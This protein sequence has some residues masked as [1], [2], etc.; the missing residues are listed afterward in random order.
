MITLR[1]HDLLLLLAVVT[2][3]GSPFAYAELAA[4]TGVSPGEVYKGLKRSEAAGLYHHETRQPEHQ[5]LCDFLLHGVRHAFPAVRGPLAR[6]VPTS[7]AAPP[8]A[9]LF[10]GGMLP[11]DLTPVWPSPH[12][13]R[14]GYGVEPLYPTVPE[15]APRSPALYELL[16][17]TDAIREGRARERNE[18]ERELRIRLAL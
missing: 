13:T 7:V 1:P 15:V 17:L 9:D 11:P 18:A 4:S 10:D 3:R 8:L 14:R 6:G 12:G 5:A 2:R 16:A